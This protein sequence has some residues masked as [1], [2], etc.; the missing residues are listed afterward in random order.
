MRFHEITIAGLPCVKVEELFHFDMQQIMDSG[1]C[2]RIRELPVSED[3][4][5]L[6]HSVVWRKDHVRVDALTTPGEFIFHCDLHQM[7]DIW[8]PYF[9]LDMDY[10]VMVKE[11]LSEHPDP[12][13]EKAL[14]YGSGIRMLRQG[15]FEALLA[16]LISQNNNIKRITKS[17]DEMCKRY[18]DCMNDR[19]ISYYS[20]PE[21]AQLLGKDFTGLG[22][23]YRERYFQEMFAEKNAGSFICWIGEVRSMYDN[24]LS[25]HSLLMEA[26]GIGTKVADCICL[27]GL[28]Q[29]EAYP[30][31][32]WMRKIIDQVYGGNFDTLP[33]EKC[34]GYV[35]QLQFYYFRSL[36]GEKHV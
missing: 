28:H 29:M 15:L 27:Y 3:N 2:F 10:Y 11:I 4:V 30:I 13:L 6:S 20:T 18:G 36:G 26:K 1:Q 19:G 8:Y 35:Q 9:N 22:L 24:Y 12:F 32:T 7:K 14:E 21:Y 16:F 23:G 34:A 5:R 17:L 25:A 33:Y 31:D